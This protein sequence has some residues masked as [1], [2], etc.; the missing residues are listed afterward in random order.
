MDNLSSLSSDLPGQASAAQELAQLDSSIISEFKAAACAVTKLYKLS[1]AKQAIVRRQGYLDAIQDLLDFMTS[2]NRHNGGGE[3]NADEVLAWALQKQEDLNTNSSE[4]TTTNNNNNNNG[5][6]TVTA[7]VAT[8]NYNYSTAPPASAE[9]VRASTAKKAAAERKEFNFHPP[10]NV[11]ALN[12]QHPLPTAIQ[13][14]SGNLFNFDPALAV[15]GPGIHHHHH[16]SNNGNNV[17][18][19]LGNNSINTTN[20][21]LT[22]SIASANSASSESDQEDDLDDDFVNGG[23]EDMKKRIKYSGTSNLDFKRHRF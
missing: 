16:S 8:S 1:G 10:D 17:N 19:S 13:S 14:F 22:T 5:S 7:S 3:R 12:L 9:A 21:N 15:T 2:S 20:T 6:R 4:P 11:P 18:M 23:S